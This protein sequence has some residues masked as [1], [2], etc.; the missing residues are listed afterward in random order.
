MK[1]A[2]TRRGNETDDVRKAMHKLQRR[3][4]ASDAEYAW[5]SDRLFVTRIFKFFMA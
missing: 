3:P 5:I 1:A 2:E 4:L